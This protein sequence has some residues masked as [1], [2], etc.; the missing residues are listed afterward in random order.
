MLRKGNTQA[1]ETLFAP[2]RIFTYLDDRF[3]TRLRDN[4]AHFV[5][6]VQLHDCLTGYIAGEKRLA[7][8][9][10]PGREGGKRWKKLQ[11][12]GFSPS[13]YVQAMRLAYCGREFFTT[14]NFPVDLRDHD[15]GFRAELFDIKTN[16]A[17]YAQP[18]LESRVADLESQMTAAFHARS[19]TQ[20]FDLA[21]ANQVL[22]QFY[23]EELG[24]S[25]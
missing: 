1:L 10:R 17:A 23:A 5:D 25:R 18:A 4:A 19:V 15:P 3:Q 12:F 24:W 16:A 20:E 13:N 22:E 11:E 8:G 2:A 14:G 9:A 6:S 21:L 7:S